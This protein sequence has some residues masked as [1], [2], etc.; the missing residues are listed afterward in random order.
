M[1]KLL[2]KASREVCTART[3]GPGATPS[4][5]EINREHARKRG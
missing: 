5:A 2:S 1:E 4:F 3:F